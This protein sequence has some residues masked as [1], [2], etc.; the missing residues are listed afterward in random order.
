MRK[1][2]VLSLTLAILLSLCLSGCENDGKERDGGVKE[3]T[4]LTVCMDSSSE[5]VD[6][7]NFFSDL[8]RACRGRNLP[9]KL[10]AVTFPESAA[11][12]ESKISAVQTEIMAGKGPDLFFV[13]CY[14]PL[15]Y[16]PQQ[17]L[18]MEP[19]RVMQAG[20]FLRLDELLEQSRT[21]DLS[22]C[23][24]TVMEAGRREEG[25]FLLPVSY[26]IPL[27]ILDGSMLKDT[28]S[29]Q[30]TAQDA[31]DSGDE[32]VGQAFRSTVFAS[33]SAMFG[34][35][36]DY[37][38]GKLLISQEELSKGMKLLCS[39]PEESGFTSGLLAYGT[40]NY[41]F[42]AQAFLRENAAPVCMAVC[43][44]TGGVTATVTQFAAINSN[45]DNPETAFSMLEA[46]LSEEL[47][48]AGSWRFG[49]TGIGLSVNDSLMQDMMNQHPYAGAEGFDDRQ[50]TAEEAG[51]IQKICSMV[52]AVNFKTE[53][54]GDLYALYLA[55]R[56]RPDSEIEAEVKEA[57]RKMLMKVAE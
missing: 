36:A 43:N 24:E 47:Q 44:N 4:E 42:S 38:A 55:C 18:F 8:Q 3:I 6:W 54:D 39:M 33:C 46:L 1:R 5:L 14:D 41:A 25:R 15:L 40:A 53:L 30:M 26:E 29:A 16:P 12:R 27:V 51:K 9:V 56:G 57:Y 45:T 28:E 37:D 32:L 7:A 11:E 50:V 34:K 35:L 17:Q 21:L 2:R 23:N 31:V 49:S 52:N 19:E 20:V 48:G 10:K 13:S 22:Q